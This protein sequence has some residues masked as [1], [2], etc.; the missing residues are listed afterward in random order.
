VF[1]A[2]CL[3][4]KASLPMC[5]VFQAWACSLCSLN[6]FQHQAWA[7][8][9]RPIGRLGARQ[10]WDL[11]V[12]EGI[13]VSELPVSITGVKAIVNHR[14]SPWISHRTQPPR[15]KKEDVRRNT[16]N[17]PLGLEVGEACAKRGR[18]RSSAG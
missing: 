17:W 9:L 14:R 4:C 5:R 18:T 3:G 11:K 2:I 8:K 12:S 15:Q 1:A 10:E 13:Q 7:Q 16:E 6:P